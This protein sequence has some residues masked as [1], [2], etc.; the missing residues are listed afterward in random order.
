MQPA[1]T[2]TTP[3]HAERGGTCCEKKSPL[4]TITTKRCIVETSVEVRADVL[5]TSTVVLSL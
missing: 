3:T 4:N 1:P 5:S 2:S